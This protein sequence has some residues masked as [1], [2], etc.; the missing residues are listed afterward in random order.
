MTLGGLGVGNRALGTCTER[1]RSIGHGDCIFIL[2]K[3]SVLPEAIISGKV[4]STL[5]KAPGRILIILVHNTSPLVN[6]TS[7]LVNNTSPLVHNTS[8][9]VHNT[10]PLV[11]N[12]SLL[13]HNTSPLVHN[14]SPLVNNTSPLVHNT[15]PLVNN[16]SLL[17]P[18]IISVQ[19]PL[20]FSCQQMILN[21][22]LKL[23]EFWMRSPSF[24]LSNANP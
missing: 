10:S 13:V 4:S 12:T 6:N 23:G 11:N 24:P 3:I 2:F 1:S 15:S 8:L 19:S 20:S 22:K 7:P 14:T 17:V 18:S 9:L 21:F 16:T 5:T